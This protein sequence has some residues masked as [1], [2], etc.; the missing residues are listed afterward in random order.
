MKILILLFLLLPHFMLNATSCRSLD[1]IEWMLGTWK[2]K[3]NDQTLIESW[4]KVSAK[5]MEGFGETLVK[6]KL[7]SSESL[8][9]VAMSGQLYFVAKVNHNAMPVAF[10]LTECSSA[11]VVF[12]NQTHD[13]PKRIEYT[14]KNNDKIQALVSDGQGEGFSIN[15]VKLKTR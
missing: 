6:G 3:H 11:H 10:K 12:E 5:T 14:F 1:T 2:S 7:K 8:R 15:F 4:N 9:V 13:F